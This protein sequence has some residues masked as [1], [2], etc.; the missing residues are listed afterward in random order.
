MDQKIEADLLVI[1]GSSAGAVA[2]IKAR[3]YGVRNVVLVE[4]G[5][6][7]K[8][9]CSAFGAGVMTVCFPED[10]AEGYRWEITA[11]NGEW[12]SD[13]LWVDILAQEGYARI[14]DLDAYGV[15]F[16]K[17]GGKFARAFGRGHKAVLRN[18]MFH[19]KQ[20][21]AALRR[22]VLVSDVKVLERVM[23][24]DLLM[25]GGRVKGAVGFHT[26]TG[27][28][29]Q[30]Q[31]KR[32]VLAAGG[33]GFKA[34]FLGHKTV[35]GDGQ[36]LSYRAGAQHANLEFA[37]QN[38]TAKD[39][40]ICGLNM[41][42]GH[43]AK[44]VNSKGEEFMWRYD[45]VYGNRASLARI[46]AGMTFEVAA[47]RGPIIM[48]TTPFRHK[49]VERMGRVVPIPVRVFRGAGLELGNSKVEWI[50]WAAPA[51][52]A[53]G[54]GALINRRCESNLPG[55]YIV[56]DSACA[57]PH[58]CSDVGGLNFVWAIVTGERAARYAA[59][60]SKGAAGRKVSPVRGSEVKRLRQKIFEPRLR[61]RGLGADELLLDLQNTIFPW[62]VGLI[63]S[64]QSLKE[65]LVKVEEIKDGLLA[66]LWARDIHELRKALEAQNMA[67]C[68]EMYLRAS[69]ARRE[70]RG[71]HLREDHP[72]VDNLNWLKRVIIYNNE[73]K[74]ATKTRPL[75]I[76][77]YPLKPPRKKVLH[78]MWA[79]A[80]GKRPDWGF[81]QNT[82]EDIA[83]W[84]SR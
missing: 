59:A 44:L 80:Q 14:C 76:E 45:P 11:P 38:T 54:G 82:E 12:M 50:H 53:N 69:L 25:E 7:G 55:L 49:D 79:V 23:V 28:F 84:Q 4:K 71:S 58:G 78:P 47:G 36:A 70:S 31:T 24:T 48:D 74:M 39:F 30:F 16:E 75:P 33:N 73:G 34:T 3:Q 57:L 68:A 41:F 17:E 83:K 60:S 81:F 1:G 32:T 77:K 13:Q 15:E 26:R 63:K 51:T 42:V 5:M 21:M 2:A 37:C 43:G 67:L 29:Y 22:K 72:L 6:L 9:G 27:D 66:K 61:V 56:G 10:S 19:G 64:E 40:D 8:T 65:A 18:V 35:T 52:I 20:M 62:R 46:A